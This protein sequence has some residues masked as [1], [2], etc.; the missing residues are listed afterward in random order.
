MS[1]GE[2]DKHTR[3]N[4][5]D[6]TRPSYTIIVG[7]DKGGGKGHIHPKDPREVTPRESARIQTFPDWWSFSGTT[8]H[9]IRQIGNAVPPVLAAKIGNE[10]KATL[11][12]K[13]RTPWKKVLELL[14]QQHL[15]KD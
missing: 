13:R 9:P 8:R 6:P 4:K 5:L 10:I 3:I 11:F 7:S 15:F 1:A 2:R 12:G 14:G